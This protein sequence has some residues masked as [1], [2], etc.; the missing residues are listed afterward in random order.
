[1]NKIICCLFIIGCCWAQS[2]NLVS[3]DCNP[4]I[5][6]PVPDC[7]AAPGKCA[8]GFF[9]VGNCRTLSFDYYKCSVSNAA[10]SAA[11]LDSIC[12]QYPSTDPYGEQLREKDRCTYYPG[13]KSFCDA[14]TWTTCCSPG[15]PEPGTPTPSEEGGE[16]GTPTNS[17][18]TAPPTVAPVE[19]RGQIHR[20]DGASLSGPACTQATSQP[21]TINGLKLIAP[22]SLGLYINYSRYSLLTPPGDDYSVT[23]DLSQQT[24]YISYACAC[25]PPIDPSYPYLCRYTGVTSPTENLNFY[26]NIA[27]IANSSWFRVWGGNLFGRQGVLSRVSTYVPPSGGELIGVESEQQALNMPLAMNSQSLG[28]DTLSKGFSFANTGSVMSA[29]GPR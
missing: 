11:D 20:D 18:T 13:T 23:L 19:I 4:S 6:S 22:G 28:Y 7:P 27:G 25:P 12:D 26:L 10:C 5:C 15:E 3:A 21:L 24:G 16:P 29:T 14:T 17:P 9:P 8:R 2:I 1:M